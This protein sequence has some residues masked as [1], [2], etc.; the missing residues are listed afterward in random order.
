VLIAWA[1]LLDGR[2]RNPLVG[3]DLLVGAVAGLAGGAALALMPAISQWLGRVPSPPIPWLDGRLLL[4]PAPFASVVLGWIPDAIFVALMWLVLVFVFRAVLRS[5]T[6]AMLVFAA[7][8]AAILGLTQP[9]D[10]VTTFVVVMAVW[11]TVALVLV[12]VGLLA[13]VMMA[14]VMRMLQESGVSLDLLASQPGFVVATL[15]VTLA[16]ALGGLYTSV[17]AA[18]T[19]LGRLFDD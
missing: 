3:R 14:F 2:W 19:S 15:A 13:T 4:G 1:R 8:A 10:R 16:P 5:E 18:A 9:F 17:S 7:M 11:T 12:R 6:A